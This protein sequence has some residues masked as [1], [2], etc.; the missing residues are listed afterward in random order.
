MIIAITRINPW[1]DFGLSLL[2]CNPCR[3]D[4]KRPLSQNDARAFFLVWHFLFSAMDLKINGL[5]FRADPFIF[6]SV[7]LNRKPI[8]F[9]Y[10]DFLY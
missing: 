7:V 3:Y 5:S 2:K 9:P 8:N 4:K 10:P 1:L 6:E